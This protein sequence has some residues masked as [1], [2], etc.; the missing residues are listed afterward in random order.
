MQT[1]SQQNKTKWLIEPWQVHAPTQSTLYV[2]VLNDACPTLKAS[3]T[4]LVYLLGFNFP[5]LQFITDSKLQSV[6]LNQNNIVNVY[7]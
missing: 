5:T 1:L 4:F 3:H 2:L 6:I 7:L